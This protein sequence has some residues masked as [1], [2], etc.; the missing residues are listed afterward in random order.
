MTTMADAVVNYVRDAIHDGDMR[1]GDWYS[2]I[3]LAEE[4]GVSRSPVR[5]G[6]LRLEEA[7]LVK[8]VK[9]RGFQIFPPSPGNVAEIFAVRLGI[10]PAAAYRAALHRQSSHLSEVY[11]LLELM[12]RAADA[13]D[14]REFFI[15]DRALHSLFF[16]MSG[17]RFGDNVV[18]RLRDITNILGHT[19]AHTSRSLQNILDEHRPII[20]AI[21]S[22]DAG[23]AREEMFSHLTT[24]GKLL[25]RQAVVAGGASGTEE[26][27]LRVER[28]WVEHVDGL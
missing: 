27:R 10:E 7:G 14:E 24:T 16:R 18:S 28:V 21:I 17:S 1:P 11:E 9:N 5:E 8:F 15:H 25:V 19:T 22:Q 2:V 3:Q 6:L 12:Q 20:E 23:E 13:D 26:V 4:M